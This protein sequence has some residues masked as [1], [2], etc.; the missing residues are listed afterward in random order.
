MSNPVGK[1][2]TKQSKEL[3][4]KVIELH[5]NGMS[6]AKIG[7]ELGFSDVAACKR[8]RKAKGHIIFSNAEQ[9]YVPKNGS[10]VC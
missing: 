10:E 6:F 3:S 1:I 4:E 7:K 8:Y 5:D 9:K 2:V